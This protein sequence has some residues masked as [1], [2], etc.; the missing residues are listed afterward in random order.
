M[1]GWN[2]ADYKRLI[3]GEIEG[4]GAVLARAGLRVASFPYRAVMSLRNV[5]YDR[6]W[7][8]V[9]RAPVP[10]ISVGNLTVGGTG[11]T[12]V[13]ELVA[14]KLRAR[15]RRVTILSRGYG[16]RDG[17]NDEALLLEQN[18]PDVPHLQ[19][20]DRVTLANIACDELDSEVLLLDDGFQH[21]R[22]ARDLDLVL[23]D[24]TNP[25][26]GDRLLPAG[27]L[28]EPVASLHRADLIS[29]TRCDAVPLKSLESIRKRI[30]A[31]NPK[32]PLLEIRF[33][34]V[35][36]S[37]FESPARDFADLAGAKALAFCGIGNPKP[38]WESLRE[39]GVSLMETRS[40][41]DHHA[42]SREDVDSLAG[43]AR[44]R[45]PDILL[46][47]QKDAVKLPV[48]T[49]GDVPLFALRIAAEVLAGEED[50][51][52][53]LDRVFPVS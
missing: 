9:H 38:F 14:R 42:Y 35:S 50:L 19:G 2:E 32:V 24:A 11:K 29:I 22:L 53:S 16:N 12:P 40:Y 5:A 52:A 7:R 45:R 48:A 36:Y 41:P 27:L 43:W 34:P 28:R 46:T 4:P 10:V 15:H 25:F 37:Q 51:D 17:C 21:R 6:R 30:V 44:E 3:A 18:L 26:G 33:R 47:T 31:V 23:V 13:V 20:P 8:T 49:L 39:L 1:L